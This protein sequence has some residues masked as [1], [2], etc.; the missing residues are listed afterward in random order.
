MRIEYIYRMQIPL[1][2]ACLCI[3]SIQKE[4]VIAF[5]SQKRS[6]MI[7]RHS[8]IS[9][10]LRPRE[11][12]GLAQGHLDNQPYLGPWSSGIISI[13][14]FYDLVNNYLDLQIEVT[15][16]IINNISFHSAFTLLRVFLHLPLPVP[17]QS[18][19]S[20]LPASS[21]AL[22]TQARNFIIIFD[23]LSLENSLSK[24][25]HLLNIC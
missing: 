17:P 14:I 4:T 21:F 11:R 3:C 18:F 7:F 2:R 16:I 15:Q 23:I 12:K 22:V 20:Q 25:R 24:S 9:K 6:Y 19:P 5:L 1:L 13:Q 8:F 10:Q